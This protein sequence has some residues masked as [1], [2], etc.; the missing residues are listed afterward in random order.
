MAYDKTTGGFGGYYGKTNDRTITIDTDKLYNDLDMLKNIQARI[1]DGV[2][3]T[4]GY[5]DSAVNSVENIGLR[6]TNFRKY[7]NDQFQ[8]DR[9]VNDM[10]KMLEDADGSTE[11]W[12]KYTDDW[13]ALDQNLANQNDQYNV[14]E[15][16]DPDAVN[17]WGGDVNYQDYNVDYDDRDYTFTPYTF[18]PT[19]YTPSPLPTYDPVGPIKSTDWKPLPETH[20]PPYYPDTSSGIGGSSPM[21]SPYPGTDVYP[22]GY[23]GYPGSGTL[24]TPSGNPY[25][26]GDPNYHPTNNIGASGILGTGSLPTGAS[27]S[28]FSG[29][30]GFNG[31][32]GGGFGGMGST[33]SGVSGNY[34]NGSG[35]GGSLGQYASSGVLGTMSAA[36][37]TGFGGT[38]GGSGYGSGVGGKSKSNA[39]DGK[40]G[41]L[42]GSMDRLIGKGASKL[43]DSILPTLKGKTSQALAAGALTAGS[44]GVAGATI[45]GGVLVGGKLRYYVFAPEDFEKLDEALQQTILNDMKDAGMNEERIELFKNATFKIPVNE[46][47]P[48]IKKVEKAYEQN[49]DFAKD[50]KDMYNYS[51]F[52]ENDDLNKYLL[53][54]AMIIDGSN[55][56]DETNIYNII[57]P[58]LEEGEIDFIYSGLIMEEYVYDDDLDHDEEEEDKEE[59][60]PEENKEGDITQATAWLKEMGAE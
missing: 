8:V 45:G 50:F 26:S 13:V 12:Q 3:A 35:I 27:L 44:L 18:T 31:Y 52:D 23:P 6:I 57:N 60:T 11:R 25:F 54:I 1:R 38:T 47:D 42:A 36:M 29:L 10:E 19:T 51:L 46:F 33:F 24:G 2:P 43:A 15:V 53:F 21:L 20:Y 41:Q 39:K 17:P 4:R 28:T 22:G 48:H 32:P 58:S 40:L 49:V 14:G 9:I 16:S 34:G 55:S 59:T 37:S 30:N 7:L 5:I 56:T